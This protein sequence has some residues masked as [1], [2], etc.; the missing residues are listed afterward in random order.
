MT[1]TAF[2]ELR[3]HA[4][5]SLRTF[6]CSKV[7]Q[8]VTV[9]LLTQYRCKLSQFRRITVILVC[10]AFVYVVFI[11]FRLT[12]ID[13]EDTQYNFRGASK[14]TVGKVGL[15]PW[16]TAYWLTD[17]EDLGDY[18]EPVVADEENAI[19]SD[20]ARIWPYKSL[21]SEIVSIQRNVRD[22]RPAAYVVVFIFFTHHHHHHHHHHHRLHPCFT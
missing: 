6:D 2:G 20:G 12:S 22:T 13:G 9:F 3:H 7:T 1:R 14:E 21:K 19:L 5:K 18:D 4:S 11:I 10:L 8:E 16:R 17:S 15:I